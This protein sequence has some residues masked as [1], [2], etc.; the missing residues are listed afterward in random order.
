MSQFDT[1]MLTIPLQSLRT[2]TRLIVISN[3]LELLI[4]ITPTRFVNVAL[5]WPMT[6]FKLDS[7]MLAIPHES[8]I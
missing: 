6:L 1:Q 2:W 5:K 8:H 3:S 7:E 4:D